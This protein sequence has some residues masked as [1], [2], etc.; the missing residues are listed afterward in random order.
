M[1]TE[2]PVLLAQWSANNWT[3]ICLNRAKQTTK[4]LSIFV[5]DSVSD[6]WDM[7]SA[8][9]QIIYNSAL[10]LISCLYRVWWLARRDSLGPSRVFL[11]PAANLGHVTGHLDSWEYVRAFQSFKDSH[12]SALPPSLFNWSIVCPPVAL[13]NLDSKCF[14]QLSL[15]VVASVLVK[16]QVRQDESK[17]FEV[18]QEATRQ[19]KTTN[20]KN[21][22]FYP[23]QDQYWYWKWGCSRLLLSCE[24][25]MGLD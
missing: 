12:C 10:A 24:W 17:P 19:V 20:H 3:E 11:E 25:M 21:S 7:P 4:K 15:K 18:L 23:V 2:V 9:K 13:D 22:P 6:C 5:D 14:Q 16:F 1:A 8:C